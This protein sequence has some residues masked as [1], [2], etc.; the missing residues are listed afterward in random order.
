MSGFWFYATD[1]FQIAL[2]ASVGW[3]LWRD[4]DSLALFFKFDLKKENKVSASF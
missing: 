2:I 3:M 1:W 4:R